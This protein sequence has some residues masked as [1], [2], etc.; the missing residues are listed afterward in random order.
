MSWIKKYNAKLRDTETIVELILVNLNEE[1]GWDFV[2]NIDRGILTI[3]T[4]N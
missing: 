1:K 4:M 2:Q 3:Y